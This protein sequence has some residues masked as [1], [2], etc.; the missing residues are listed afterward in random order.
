MKILAIG[1]L[2]LLS[3][4]GILAQEHPTVTSQPNTIFVGADGKFEAAPDTAVLQ[5]SISAQ[6]DTSRAAFDRAS[7]AAEQVRQILRSNGIEPKTAEIGF[8]SLDPVYDYKNAKRKL[9]AYR[10]NATVTLKLKD[11]LKLAPILQQLADSDIT[12]NQ[13][14][15]YTLESIDAAKAKAVQDAY[16][17]AHES[18]EVIARASGRTLGDLTYASVD[19]F[20]NIRPVRPIMAERMRMNSQ[21]MTPAPTEEFSTQNITVTAHVNAMFVLK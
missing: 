9:V 14:V 8:F 19:T 15:N 21:A 2:I 5:F 4:A 18:A 17:R 16:R 6:E 1:L 13:S 10:V 3:T 12:D 20:E 7:K 11:F